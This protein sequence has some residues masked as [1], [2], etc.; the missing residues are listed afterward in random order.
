MIMGILRHRWLSL[1]GAILALMLV[2]ATPGAAQACQSPADT[3]AL[4][5]AVLERVNAERARSGLPALGASGP[6][7]QA[8][9][10]HACYLAQRGALS[11]RGR[12]GESLG[13]RL[14]REGYALSRAN[15]NLALGQTSPAQAVG[16]WMASPAHRA[17]VLMNGMRDFGL[18]V[19]VTGNGRLVWV[20]VSARPR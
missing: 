3:V 18:G 5:M 2:I 12:L 16:S 4:R 17:N 9:Q 11:H 19:A 1:P 8:A 20:M 13:R 14:R 7:T 10:G 15:E 6:L